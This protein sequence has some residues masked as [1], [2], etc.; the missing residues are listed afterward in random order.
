MTDFQYLF[1][2]PIS[3]LFGI[4]P[5]RLLNR[6][7]G[8]LL[9]PTSRSWL[10]SQSNTSGKS[11][12]W[13]LVGLDFFMDIGIFSSCST[14]STT[15][16]MPKRNYNGPLPHPFTSYTLTAPHM[17]QD[18]CA[19]T[20]THKEAKKTPHVVYGMEALKKELDGKTL[21]CMTGMRPTG[22]LHLG[23]YV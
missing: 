14:F 3:C 11:Q 10:H 21:T 22:R 15:R 6:L 16:E 5:F 17:T 23:H 7:S 20:Q 4:G 2:L 19:N 12:G 9:T 13:I 8:L 18:S 1:L